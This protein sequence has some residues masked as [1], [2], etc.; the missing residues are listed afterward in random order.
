LFCPATFAFGAGFGGFHR[1]PPAL[2]LR[3]PGCAI[4]PDICFPGS[5]Q[6]VVARQLG[7]QFSKTAPPKFPGGSE[8][9][10]FV[11]GAIIAAAEQTK[12]QESN[13]A[14]F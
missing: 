10:V 8:E 5:L 4:L 9:V 6:L 1:F 14:Q 11:L 2:G 7:I 3:S 13:V 12:I